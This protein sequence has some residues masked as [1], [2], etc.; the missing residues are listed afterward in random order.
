MSFRVNG[1]NLKMSIHHKVVQI[2]GAKPQKRRG[3]EYFI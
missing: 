1:Q 2:S 3:E